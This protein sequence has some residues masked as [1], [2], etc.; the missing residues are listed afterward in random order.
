VIL[1]ALLSAGTAHAGG[2]YQN[3]FDGNTYYTG[4][5]DM[6]V[7]FCLSTGDPIRAVGAGVVVGIQHD[8]Y[9]QQPYIWYQLTAGPEAGRYVY[10]AEQIDHLAHIGQTL[11]AGDVVARYAKKGTCLETGWS[12]ADGE[13]TASATTGYTEGQVT[14]AGVSFARFLISVNVQGT[15]E[16]K[17]TP[18]AAPASKG[19]PPHKHHR[20][21]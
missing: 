21:A 1:F 6:G 18:P 15:F 16:L 13:T 12:E 7:D 4:R 19:H 9:K 3:P 20:P 17:P 8:W 10:V 5:T 11:K 2:G 14:K